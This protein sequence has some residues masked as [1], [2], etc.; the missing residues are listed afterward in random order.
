V[1]QKATGRPGGGFIEA[2][3]HVGF[4]HPEESEAEIWERALRDVYRYW[5]P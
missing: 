2:M 3:A 1:V 5:K 4:A